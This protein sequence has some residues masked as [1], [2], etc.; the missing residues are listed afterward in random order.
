MVLSADGRYLICGDAAGLLYI[1]TVSSLGGGPCDTITQAEQDKAKAKAKG[2]AASA[3]TLTPPTADNGPTLPL[4]TLELHNKKGIVTNLVASTRPL[5]LF[6]LTANLKQYDPGQIQ[7]LQKVMP[8]SDTGMTNA[9]LTFNQLGQL[10]AQESNVYMDNE[11]EFNL[12][13]ANNMDFDLAELQEAEYLGGAGACL[14]TQTK[15]MGKT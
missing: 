3:T 11:D 14:S 8:V 1:W 15:T 13:F 4:R 5:S 6:G 7:P 12:N 2:K 9:D 10:Q